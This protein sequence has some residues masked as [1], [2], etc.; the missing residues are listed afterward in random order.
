MS[1]GVDQR[2]HVDEVGDRLGRGGAAGA[3]RLWEKFGLPVVQHGRAAD[4]VKGHSEDGIV[5]G[6]GP[7][8]GRQ[9]T[10]RYRLQAGELGG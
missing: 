4:G 8:A 9:V 6:E 2:G 7:L 3:H 10:H 5:Q 1:H